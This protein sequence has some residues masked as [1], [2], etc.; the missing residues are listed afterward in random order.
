MSEIYIMCFL[1]MTISLACLFGVYA[2]GRRDKHHKAHI[3]QCER[4]IQ[5]LYDVLPEYLG[6]D[7]ER[8]LRISRHENKLSKSK[9]A[10]GERW[11]SDETTEIWPE[12]ITP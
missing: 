7:L 11:H 2:P 5:A 9:L 4:H 8:N 12:L 1:M 6:Q 10:I 3:H